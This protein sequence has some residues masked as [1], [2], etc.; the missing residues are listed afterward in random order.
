[1]DRLTELSNGEKLPT[2][3]GGRRPIW[4]GKIWLAEMTTEEQQ[5]F[6]DFVGCPYWYPCP[7][8][9]HLATTDDPC[10]GLACDE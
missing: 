3:P 6:R 10:V 1:M 9:G 2:F 7:D 8:C 5:E 4:D